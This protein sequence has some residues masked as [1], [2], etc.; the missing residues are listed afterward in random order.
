MTLAF[1]AALP[2][3]GQGT[4]QIELPQGRP[5]RLVV[6]GDHPFPDP[7]GRQALVLDVG[8]KRVAFRTK[9]D[10]DQDAVLL[11][12]T[13]KAS[14]VVGSAH[15][16][17]FSIDRVNRRLRYGKGYP[18][19]SLTL[20]EHELPPRPHEGSADP[21]AWIDELR[22]VGI[23]AKLTPSEAA[24]EVRLGVQSQPVTTDLPPL[25]IDGDAI[26]LDDID[27]HSFAIVQDIGPE[28][29]RLYANVAGPGVRLSPA[30]IE[31]LRASIADP[32]RICA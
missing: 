9:D 30:F 22:Y 16:Y 13:D 14:A 21:F 5:F 11:P 32:R 31:A 2:V 15:R 10:D 18:Q 27:S 17:W 23:H 4:V 8:D 3:H 1:Q 26:T 29:A 19:A 28:C 12:T 6:H 20:F 25:L 24:S 7:E